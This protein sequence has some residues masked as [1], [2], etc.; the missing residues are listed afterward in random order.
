MIPSSLLL[1]LG[2]AA[3]AAGSPIA[4]PQ[5]A[6]DGPLYDTNYFCDLLDTDDPEAVANIWNDGYCDGDE[7][8]IGSPMTMLDLFTQDGNEAGW[9]KN[10]A[11]QY[12]ENPGDLGDANCGTIGGSCELKVPS[13]EVLVGEMGLPDLYLIFRAV[14]G[15]H[16]QLNVAQEYL[17]NNVINNT[18]LLDQIA[19][20]FSKPVDLAEQRRFAEAMTPLAVANSMLLEIKSLLGQIFFVIGGVAGAVSGGASFVGVAAASAVALATSQLAAAQAEEDEDGKKKAEARLAG[21]KSLQDKAGAAGRG[22][23]AIAAGT[24]WASMLTERRYQTHEHGTAKHPLTFV[25]CFQLLSSTHPSFRESI[26]FAF[27][28]FNTKLVDQALITSG[29]HIISADVVDT[30]DECNDWNNEVRVSQTN[31]FSS[32]MDDQWSGYGARWV[33]MGDGNTFVRAKDCDLAKTS[34]DKGQCMNLFR[35]SSLHADEWVVAERTVTDNMIEKYGIDI[36]GYYK[37]AYECS[38]YGNEERTPDEAAVPEDGSLPTCWFGVPADR[39][40]INAPSGGRGGGWNR[41]D[42]YPF[43]HA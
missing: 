6:S 11:A 23:G 30:E 41:W 32:L 33:D 31:V 1:L 10:L 8:R 25:F 3:V 12:L 27:G 42:L 21:A 5:D 2:L 13:C 7:C 4:V 18:L 36:V 17:Q 40:K 38:K 26:E 20:D 35:E 29:L 39:A 16:S 9:L 37:A 14:E 24:Y 34:A 19:A 43:D 28:Q 22:S 15:F